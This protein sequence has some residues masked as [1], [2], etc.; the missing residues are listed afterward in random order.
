MRRS[1]TNHI[2]EKKYIKAYSVTN[3]THAAFGSIICH[4]FLC[5]CLL[6]LSSSPVPPTKREAPPWMTHDNIKHVQNQ[7]PSV[8]SPGAGGRAPSSKNLPSPVP[9]RGTLQI[10]INMTWLCILW[11]VVLRF[12]QRVSRCCVLRASYV[13]H[14]TRRG[15]RI[16]LHPALVC[17]LHVTVE[18]AIYKCCGLL[19]F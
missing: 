6:T 18:G 8:N 4:Q 11:G 13:S 10:F 9:S 3:A 14:H 15:V 16:T 1:S 2:D 7:D 5:G 19:F 12:Y 17:V